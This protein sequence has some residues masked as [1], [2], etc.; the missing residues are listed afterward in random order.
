VR[1]NFRRHRKQLAGLDLVVMAR[2]AA[3]SASK[4]QLNFSLAEHMQKLISV[5]VR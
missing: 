4:K 3:D 1:E 2:P 5:S